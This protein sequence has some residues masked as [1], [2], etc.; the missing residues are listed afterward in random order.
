[1]PELK[2]LIL[3]CNSPV[4]QQRDGKGLVCLLRHLPALDTRNLKAILKRVILAR[5]PNTSPN[6]RRLCTEIVEQLNRLGC[7]E[8]YPDIMMSC[9][10]HWNDVATMKPGAFRSVVWSEL[11]RFVPKCLCDHAAID[12]IMTKDDLADEFEAAEALV[13][14]CTFAAKIA[15]WAPAEA[16][17][18]NLSRQLSD[19]VRGSLCQEPPLDKIT[20]AHISTVVGDCLSLVREKG[21]DLRCTERMIHAQLFQK[22][23]TYP[24]AGSMQ[25]RFQA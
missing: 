11:K 16:R 7:D 17:L 13:A 24:V 3:K 15:G 5:C 9:K 14:S 2:D 6:D 25:E 1:M 18:N 12:R 23:I 8:R 10:Q 19:I 20:Q 4:Y 21:A 22:N